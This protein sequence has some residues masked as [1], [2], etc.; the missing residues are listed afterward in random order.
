[1]RSA[2]EFSS[3][4]S[5]R[6]EW[7]GRCRIRRIDIPDKEE[8]F[9]AWY[10]PDDYHYF[11]EER[12][13]VLRLT[14]AIERESSIEKNDSLFCPRGIRGL[15]CLLNVLD[16]QAQQWEKGTNS[17]D[18]AIAAHYHMVARRCK[19][20][21]HELA[22]KNT[23][24]IFSKTQSDDVESRQPVMGKENNSSSSNHKETMAWLTCKK[25]ETC[26]ASNSL[27]ANQ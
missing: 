20:D 13:S 3:T 26:D 19:D 8:R 14:T 12:N 16:E 2:T 5:K 15:E 23:G 11:I 25:G 18:E 4:I 21:A 24:T 9:D 7:K 17:P 27:D 10:Q 6:V 22:K 1:M